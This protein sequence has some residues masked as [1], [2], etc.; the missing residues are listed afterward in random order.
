MGIVDWR[1]H[2]HDDHVGFAQHRRV[3]RVDGVLGQRHFVVG[4]FARRVDSPQARIHLVLG[5]VEADGPHVL[6]KFDHQGQADVTQAD[7]C[8]RVHCWGA[9]FCGFDVE[10]GIL[11]GRRLSVV[12]RP[13]AGVNELRGGAPG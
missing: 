7:D 6:P 13:P 12:Q 3:V 10:H 11:A 4:E 2:G 1:W 5:D 9:L 8:E